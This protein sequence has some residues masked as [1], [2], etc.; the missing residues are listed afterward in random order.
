MNW[1]FYV[2]RCVDGSL[3]AGVTTEI[4]RRVS[5]HNR[6]KRGAKYTRSRRPVNLVYDVELESRS[7][8]Q[9]L[10]SKFKRLTRLN[11]ISFLRER[12]VMN[13]G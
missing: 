8:A 11:K 13:V 1:F 4:E 12:G 7:A 10:E 3:Y 5:E 2:V 6:S 9:K